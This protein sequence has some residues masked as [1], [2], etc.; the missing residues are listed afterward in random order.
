LCNNNN[1]KLY[2]QGNVEQANIDKDRIKQFIE[3]G[4]DIQAGKQ[5]TY[6]QRADAKKIDE[7]WDDYYQ[8]LKQYFHLMFALSL[9]CHYAVGLSNNGE[10]MNCL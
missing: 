9:I 2:H 8:Q 1:V 3:I 10:N 7:L 6:R 4:L 5:H